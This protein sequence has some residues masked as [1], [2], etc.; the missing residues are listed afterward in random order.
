MPASAPADSRLERAG[1]AATRALSVAGLVALM[2][3]A[4]MTLADGLMRWLANRPIEGVR[5]VGALAIAVAVA[6]C[7]PVGLMERSN[8]TMRLTGSL[9]GARAGRIFDALAALV[10]EAVLVLMAWQFFVHASKIARANETTWILKIP[11]APFWYIVDAMLWC[12][13]AVQAIV[14]ALE[15]LRAFP[16]AQPGRAR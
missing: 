2:V 9:F 3:L 6:S 11:T 5:D 12:A 7:L 1:L 13:V 14:V 4:T 16:A 8:I 15:F 10:V